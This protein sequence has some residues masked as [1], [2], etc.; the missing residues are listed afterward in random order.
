MIPFLRFSLPRSA[1]RRPETTD[2]PGDELP[3]AL[4]RCIQKFHSVKTTVEDE[5]EKPRLAGRDSSRWSRY[6]FAHSPCQTDDIKRT[7][8]HEPL[9]EGFVGR[10]QEEE[11]SLPEL[12]TNELW[13]DEQQALVFS[14]QPDSARLDS[15][16]CV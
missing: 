2:T 14:H 5:L 1:R 9:I 13:Y 4:E 15:S 16:P 11:S 12:E 10:R 3:G 6:I 8:D 7:F